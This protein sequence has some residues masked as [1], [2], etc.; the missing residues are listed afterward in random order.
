VLFS[1]HSLQTIN[2]VGK[3]LVYSV[4]CNN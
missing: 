3:R 2:H 4:Y 1:R